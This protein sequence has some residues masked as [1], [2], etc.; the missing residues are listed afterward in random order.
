MPWIFNYA[1][2]GPQ[3]IVSVLGK[4]PFCSLPATLPRYKVVFQGRSRKWSGA[5]ASL[6]KS[7]KSL[8]YGTAMLVSPDDQKLFDR[9]HKG[10]EK[11]ELPIFIDATQDK[12]K[13]ETYVVPNKTYGTPS[14]DYIKA[15]VKHLKF[16]W[17]QGQK[18]LS[19]VDF[20]I[21]TEV[22]QPKQ[23][24]KTAAKAE[25]EPTPA[26]PRRRGR[27]KTNQK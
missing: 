23:P 19:L 14:L 24:K 17:G 15:M 1:E 6:E 22:P 3:D 5:L 27:K 11:I 10:L 26:K 7:G 9:A 20:G 16:F 2:R 12:V 8:V 25:P 18:N 4:A 21:S 13:A